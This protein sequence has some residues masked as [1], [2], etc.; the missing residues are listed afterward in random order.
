V[1]NC[2]DLIV[3]LSSMV[4]LDCLK[5]FFSLL[6]DNSSRAKE[7][8]KLI[9]VKFTFFKFAAFLKKSLKRK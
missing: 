1:L 5:R 2:K 4:F 9:S 6:V 8:A 7:L 3:E